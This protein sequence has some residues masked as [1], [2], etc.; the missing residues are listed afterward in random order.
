MRPTFKEQLTM[1]QHTLSIRRLWAYFLTALVMALAQQ[2]AHALCVTQQEAGSWIN[3]DPNTNSQTRIDLSF[4]CQDVIL[5]GKPFPP[6]P[7]WYVRVFGKCHPTDCDWGRV[8][9]TR[10]STGFVYAFYNQGFAKRFVYAKMSTVRPGQLWVQT[11]TQF[12]DG[13]PSYTTSNY[14]IRR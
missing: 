14:F 13:R 11:V 3:A 5:N 1:S 7:P 10:L 2:S 4:V 9:A 12:T 6:G 8:G